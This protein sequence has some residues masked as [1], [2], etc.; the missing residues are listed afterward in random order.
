M[1]LEQLEYLIE[2]Q[3][4]KSLSAAAQKLHLSSQALSKSISRMEDE[5]G[6]VLL[7]RSYKGVYLTDKAQRLISASKRFFDELAAISG[8][9]SCQLPSLKGHYEL[10]SIQGE[11][12]NFLL[13]LLATLSHDFPSLE[14][15]VF[16]HHP[17]E[18]VQLVQT[19]TI[20][21]GFYCTCL[22]NG[23]FLNSLPEELVFTPLLPAKLHVLI[24]NHSPLA[25]Y[26]SVSIKTLLPYPFI[27]QCTKETKIPYLQSLINIFGTPKQII[28]KT[29]VPLCYELVLAG[30]GNY[31]QIAVVNNFPQLPRQITVLPIRDEIEMTYG[32][33]D[34]KG[35]LFTSTSEI[36]LQYIQNHAEMILK[37]S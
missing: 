3:K 1:H 35:H 21:F 11:L 9:P 2:I 4:N 17:E 27:M 7:N 6:Y 12:N 31:L 15:H 33:I 22:I 10:N 37:Q 29:S 25:V 18:I 20:D 19:E 30:M 16:S 24:S 14:V 36:I 28:A 5:L 8:K 23:N 32:Y 13:A 26:K 34:K